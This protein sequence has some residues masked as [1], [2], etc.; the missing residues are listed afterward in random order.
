MLEGASL[1]DMPPQR[2]EELAALVGNQSMAALL[3]Q[4]ALPLEEISFLLPEPVET[5]PYPVPDTEPVPTAQ[6]PA[7]TA[8][9]T[10]GRAF[11]PAGL[12]YEGGTAHG[13]IL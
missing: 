11:D 6:P 7:L 9:E 3:E 12:V 8:G 2:L 10:A 5:I 1:L 13:A 4:Q